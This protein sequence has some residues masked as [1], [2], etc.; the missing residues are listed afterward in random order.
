[1]IISWRI[2]EGL[3]LCSVV[4]YFIY[5]DIGDD[6]LFAKRESISLSK[7]LTA[8]AYQAVTA[9]DNVLGR[10]GWPCTAIDVAA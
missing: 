10:L 5:I 1:M 2:S 6:G 7:R 3:I 4:S 9:K 8:F